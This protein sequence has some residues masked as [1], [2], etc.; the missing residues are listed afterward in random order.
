MPMLGVPMNSAWAHITPVLA[1]TAWRRSNL[2]DFFRLR[3]DSIL[4]A[5]GAMPSEVRDK[6]DRNGGRYWIR[7]SDLF[8]VKEAI[9]H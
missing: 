4:I 9:Y 5:I 2:N 6:R 1:I 8:R 3:Q 7:T